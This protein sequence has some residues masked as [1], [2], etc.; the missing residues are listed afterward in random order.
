MTEDRIKART[1]VKIKPCSQLNKQMAEK[2]GRKKIE[3][4]DETSSEKQS[5]QTEKHV[6]MQGIQVSLI[7][8]DP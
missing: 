1:S 4:K 6:S 7:Q 2:E 3:R 8:V 5:D